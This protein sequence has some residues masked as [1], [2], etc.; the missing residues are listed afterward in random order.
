LLA[1]ASV[2]SAVPQRG[3]VAEDWSSVPQLYLMSS[4]SRQI[5][6]FPALRDRIWQLEAAGLGRLLRAASAGDPDAASDRG[7]RFGRLIGP[8][9]RKHQH[10][11]R[12]LR[13]AFP[14]MPQRTV[15]ATAGRIWGAIGRTLV[16]YAL[17]DRIC[18]PASGRVRVIDLGGL[19]HIRRTGR[20]GI[21]VSAHLANWNL[22]PLAAAHASVPLTVVYRRQSNPAIER[23]M[24]DWRT[25]LGCGLLEVKE[26]S[27][28]ML[29][30]LQQ[31]RSVGLLIDQRYDLG[32]EVPFFGVPAN[33][34]VV[35][36]RLALRLGLPLIPVRVERRG[37]AWFVITVQR[38]V[39][40]E[41]GLAEG[42]A[43]LA[44]TAKVNG[45]FARW[46]TAAPEQ[47]LCAKRRWPRPHKKRASPA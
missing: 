24:D 44:M 9:L 21:F 4:L 34:T 38:P 42:D 27:R 33:T 31:G 41:P 16:E 20:P 18:D 23:L 45:L 5:D 8:H 37:S 40:P 14:T 10:V 39:E 36:A 22:L 12:N 43:A 17:L 7:E 6:R 13:T 26:A 32:Q 46:I 2:C 47:W 30:E 1:A 29:R 28:P 19:E 15:E 3:I 11:L 35:P 25:P